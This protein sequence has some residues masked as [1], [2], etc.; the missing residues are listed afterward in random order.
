M[1][2]QHITEEEANQAQGIVVPL[3]LDG[4][5]I[6]RQEV[7]ADGKLRVEVMATKQ[8][9]KCPHCGTMCVKQHDVRPRRKRDVPGLRACGGVGA[10]QTAVLV[11]R[12]SQSFHRKR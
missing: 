3:E 4:L 12:M 5:R 9:E 8:R 7:Q 2:R 10:A 6:L 1:P 11:Q